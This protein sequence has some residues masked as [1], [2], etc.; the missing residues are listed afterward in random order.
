MHTCHFSGFSF[1]SK[2]TEIRII[3]HRECH[4][5]VCP[6]FV[7]LQGPWPVQAPVCASNGFT[8]G[9]IHQVRCLRELQPGQFHTQ[10]FFLV[11]TKNRMNF[12]IFIRN[13]YSSDPR[14][15]LYAARNLPS[16]GSKCA[17]KS[18]LIAT[19]NV[20]EESDLYEPQSNL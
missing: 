20:R 19:T 15:W 6:S 3:Y 5:L 16:I 4:P 14:G 10:L 9:H 8:Y 11:A 2:S 1:V 7:D 17:H 18:V 13:R 12:D